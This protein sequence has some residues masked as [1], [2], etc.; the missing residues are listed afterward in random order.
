VTAADLQKRRM[1]FIIVSNAPL[2]LLVAGCSQ[3]TQTVVWDDHGCCPLECTALADR[4][5]THTHRPCQTTRAHRA[6]LIS[7]SVALSQIPTYAERPL[8]WG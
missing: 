4:L 8:I 7:V 1:V 5:D 2:A 3:L 6:G